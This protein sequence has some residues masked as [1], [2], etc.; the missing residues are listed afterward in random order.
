MPK[1]L[2]PVPHMP[3]ENDGDCLAACTAMV[4]QYLQRPLPYSQ[5]RQLLK[6]RAYGAPA[7]NVRYLT[8]LGFA[9][10]FSQIDMPGLEDWIEQG[11]PV[12]TFVRTG[13][14]PHWHYTTDHAVVV[15]GYDDDALYLN[16]PNENKAPIAVPRGDFELAWL[17]RDYAYAVIL[18]GD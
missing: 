6:I 5:I 11:Q 13:D 9:V 8:Q 4:L 1:T 17:E 3:Q 12:M 18:P 14:L 16:D 15:V 2:L 10:V 7:G